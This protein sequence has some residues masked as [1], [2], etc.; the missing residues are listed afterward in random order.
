[1]R[2]TEFLSEA[3]QL[4]QAQQKRRLRPVNGQYPPLKPEEQYVAPNFNLFKRKRPA[5]PAPVAKPQISQQPELDMPNNNG[6]RQGDMFKGG[7]DPKVE[8]LP[9]KAQAQTPAT[10]WQGIVTAA[11]NNQVLGRELMTLIGAMYQAKRRNPDVQMSEPKLISTLKDGDPTKEQMIKV[12]NLGKSKDM[13]GLAA[14]ASEL[15][16]GRKTTATPQQA[17]PQQEKRMSTLK[18]LLNKEVQP[19][20]TP[21]QL[22]AVA[23]AVR[24]SK[25]A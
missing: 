12:F 6:E 13:A 9:G 25:R 11:A 16:K 24:Q 21:Q 2:F 4:Q 10:E 1:M 5:K 7:P 8:P 23:K 3:P 20:L 18:T 19:A 17:N 15:Q 22:D 14:L